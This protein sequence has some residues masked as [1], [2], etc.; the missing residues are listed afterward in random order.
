MTM[1][2]EATIRVSASGQTAQIILSR[3]D[4]HNAF[5]DEMIA[6]LTAAISDL[7]GRD[8]VRAVVVSGAGK[9]FCAGADVN[10]MKRMVG[11]SLEENVADAKTLAN[12][13]RAI[14][15]CP[16][17]V[18][19]SV[20]G[21]CLGGGVGLVAAADMAVALESAVFGLTEAR[22]GIIPAVISP[23]LL[24][25]IGPGH[26]RRYFLTAERYGAA[27]A[28]R[29]GL[30]SHVAATPADAETWIGQV[31]GEIALN[32]PQAVAAAK[33]LIDKVLGCPSSDVADLTSRLIAE[34]RVSPE[35]Q[36]GLNSFLQKRRPDWVSSSR[37]P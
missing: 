15:D 6:E 20:H 28:H 16:L 36:E 21:N 26:A 24:R 3:S 25:K 37:S 34:R 7:G 10:W 18:I 14:R 19:A 29:I 13:L 8:G 17:P 9:S 35:G 33:A 12:M 32:G 31:V 4:V 2:H 23:F 22:L 1:N 27:E 30:V 5:N 11:Y